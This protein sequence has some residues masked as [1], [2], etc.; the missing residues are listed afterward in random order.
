MTPE[1]QASA[2]L[3]PWKVLLVDDEPEVHEVTRL[4]LAGPGARDLEIGRFLDVR[5]TGTRDYDLVA[6]PLRRPAR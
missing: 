1:L 6:A 4:I 3:A 2:A 5:I